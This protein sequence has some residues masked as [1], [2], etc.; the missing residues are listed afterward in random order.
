MY[1]LLHKTVL[2]Q[3]KKNRQEGKGHLLEHAQLTPFGGTNSASGTSLR[4][5]RKRERERKWYYSEVIVLKQLYVLLKSCLIYNPHSR[6]IT[7]YKSER[8]RARKRVY[9]SV[10]EDEKERNLKQSALPILQLVSR[11]SH[12]LNSRNGF[13]Q[14]A[15]GCDSRPSTCHGERIWTRHLFLTPDLIEKWSQFS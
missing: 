13:Y 4:G 8:E 5:W 2:E 7:V 10:E 14:I 9:I 15:W 12:Y 3:K 6:L 1:A 11:R